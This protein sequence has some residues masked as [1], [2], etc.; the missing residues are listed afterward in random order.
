MFQSDAARAYRILLVDDDLDTLEFQS[1]FLTRQGWDV[2]RA[3]N[4]H[5]ALALLLRAA[6]DVLVTD[7]NMPGMS[8]R[9]LCEAVRG[10]P[11]LGGIP[12]LIISGSDD[13]R[14]VATACG[15]NG[16]VKKP[17]DADRLVDEVRKLLPPA[18]V[19]A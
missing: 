10:M 5:E 14:A 11:A 1:E 4:G 2:E 9:A 6:P 8:G 15:A 12:I 16:V 13:A 18:S 17:F 3:S 7:L 19:L